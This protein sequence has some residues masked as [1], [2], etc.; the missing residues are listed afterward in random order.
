VIKL[1]VLAATNVARKAT[2][3]AAQD[4]PNN[5]DANVQTPLDMKLIAHVRLLQ[6][7]DGFILSTDYTPSFPTKKVL[8][9]QNSE[10]RRPES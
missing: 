8:H 6:S 2:R 10:S 9:F 3:K 5:D 4:A 1:Y 7:E